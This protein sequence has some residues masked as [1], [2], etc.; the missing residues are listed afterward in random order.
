MSRTSKQRKNTG[1]SDLPWWK[2]KQNWVAI[3]VFSALLIFLFIAAM[4]GSIGSGSSA[5]IT[6]GASF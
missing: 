6:G 3:A 4:G 5:R 1:Q 2:I